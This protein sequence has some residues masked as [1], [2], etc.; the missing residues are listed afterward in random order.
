MYIKKYLVLITFTSTALKGFSQTATDVS[1][2][3]SN[4]LVAHGKVNVTRSVATRVHEEGLGS[5]GERGH[6]SPGR[7]VTIIIPVTTQEYLQAIKIRT[8][9]ISNL[10]F[11]KD[12]TISLPDK[13]IESSQN[14]VNT[15][16]INSTQQS[17]LSLSYTRSTSISFAHSVTHTTAVGAN[18]T[19]KLTN[20]FSIGGNIQVS[21]SET[22]G[23][24]YVIGENST[25]TKSSTASATLPP[26]SAVHVSFKEWTV[27]HQIKFKCVVVVDA[28]IITND[29]GI[30]LLS[31][32][33]DDKSRTFEI[34]GIIIADD[35]SEGIT[36]QSDPIKLTNQQIKNLSNAN[37]QFK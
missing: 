36:T 17:T 23:T 31:Q 33:A 24:T 15:S 4:I 5:V 26:K 12:D 14:L 16:S 13:F 28:D 10:E 20:A 18:F 35:C 11:G 25:V 32:I 2:K 30:I 34:S 7:W 29:A 6:V 9:K 19:L 1:D 27:R 8:L 37:L 21:E 3:V 22:N